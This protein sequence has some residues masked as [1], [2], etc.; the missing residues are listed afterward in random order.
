MVVFL[1]PLAPATRLLEKRWAYI[2]LFIW[3]FSFAI[4]VLGL[5]LYGFFPSEHPGLCLAGLC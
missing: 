3:V 5:K 1:Q 2:W 4:A